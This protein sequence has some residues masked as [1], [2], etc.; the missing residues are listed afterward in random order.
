MPRHWTLTARCSARSAM[1]P[2]L[3][4]EEPAARYK[5]RRETTT[6]AA[7][8][9]LKVLRLHSFSTFNHQIK[10]FNVFK[11]GYGGIRAPF[12]GA[13][14]DFTHLS[15]RLTSRLSHRIPQFFG[16]IPGGQSFQIATPSA[17]LTNVTDEGTG[18]N[19][20]PS[21]RG[22]T[23]LILVGGDNR[24]VGSGGSVAANVGYGTNQVNNCLSNNSPSSTPGSPAGGTY[25][26]T[27]S[28]SSTSNSGSH[29]TFV[30]CF[31]IVQKIFG[32]SINCA[33]I[34]AR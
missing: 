29:A 33:E 22:M 3:V 4:Q 32:H 10:L 5:S 13:F 8:T 21:V 30:S 16:V 6:Q 20:T 24:G 34:P 31:P 9:Q 15:C 2:A 23:T 25:P 11:L 26:T 17:S 14:Y 19:W 7:T 1:L 27:S 28:S 18:F 12:K